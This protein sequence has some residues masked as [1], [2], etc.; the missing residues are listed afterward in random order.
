MRITWILLIV[1]LANVAYPSRAV[2][3]DKQ[4]GYRNAWEKPQDR[5]L[6]LEA[7][8]KVIPCLRLPTLHSSSFARRAR[9][10]FP[11]LLFSYRGSYILLAG[12]IRQ[13]FL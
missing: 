8:A 2:A 10:F 4:A 7:V 5:Q 13:L 9:E 6:R 3:G 1:L 11:S 12:K